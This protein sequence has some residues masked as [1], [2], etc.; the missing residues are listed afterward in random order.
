VRSLGLLDDA[1]WYTSGDGVG[2][3]IVQHD[4]I[5]A[6][7]CA[8]SDMDRPED[9]RADA[10]RYIVSDDRHTLELI[11]WAGASNDNLGA[12]DTSLTETSPLVNDHRH[13]SVC[14][15]RSSPNL[16]CQGNRAIKKEK[17]ET[18]ADP[19]QN[20]DVCTLKCSAGTVE[21]QGFDVQCTTP[22][23]IGN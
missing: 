11:A 3:N 18:L 23:P 20:G 7:H 21:T 13:T 4:C 5:C 8:V 6:N 19:G 14:A 15:A 16:C 17:D 9:L 1:G 22:D 12:D 10:K 2:G